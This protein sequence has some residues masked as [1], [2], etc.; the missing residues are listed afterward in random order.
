MEATPAYLDE[1]GQDDIESVL[2]SA[3][4]D[5]RKTSADG[6]ADWKA[7]ITRD[8]RLGDIDFSHTAHKKRT[9]VLGSIVM[10]HSVKLHIVQSICL[11]VTVVA[12]DSKVV[13][14]SEADTTALHKA[15]KGMSTQEHAA[16]GPT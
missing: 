8:W 14:T 9:L 6:R 2:F 4:N 3:G 7:G 5:L 12:W 1:V 10:Q 16:L 13:V 15:R 11:D